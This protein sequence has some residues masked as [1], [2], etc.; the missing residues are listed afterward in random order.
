[1]TTF[2]GFAIPNHF[3]YSPAVNQACLTIRYSILQDHLNNHCGIVSVL[4]SRSP[5]KT[6]DP[7]F[8]SLMTSE[9]NFLTTSAVS[10]F[11]L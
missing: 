4:E 3:R 8:E 9:I 5:N 6:I 10:S 2:F 11:P 1:M 7:N